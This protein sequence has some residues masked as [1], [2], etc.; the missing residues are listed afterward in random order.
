[1]ESPDKTMVVDVVTPQPGSSAGLADAP[2]PPPALHAGPAEAPTPPP[3]NNALN[4][5]E[6]A[7]QWFSSA[8]YD[9]VQA[10]VNHSMQN[11]AIPLMERTVGTAFKRSREE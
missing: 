9:V 5:N 7:P 10:A 3:G 2:P 11:V 4:F 6:S 8:L 1:M